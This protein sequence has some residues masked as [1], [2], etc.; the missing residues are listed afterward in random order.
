VAFLFSGDK[1]LVNS[2]AGTAQRS[3]APHVILEPADV[4]AVAID[5]VLISSNLAAT[6]VMPTVKRQPVAVLLQLKFKLAK[7]LPVPDK[8]AAAT[9]LGGGQSR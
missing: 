9:G 3:V 6:G 4:G 8:I 5:Q 2:A 1:V 7:L